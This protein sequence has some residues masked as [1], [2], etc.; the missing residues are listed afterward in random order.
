M[1]ATD[2][3]TTK[4]FTI[5]DLQQLVKSLKPKYKLYVVKENFMLN[6]NLYLL[7]NELILCTKECRDSII[8][9]N[10]FQVEELNDVQY[11]EYM[12]EKYNSEILKSMNKMPF[13]KE[14]NIAGNRE[15]FRM[16][17]E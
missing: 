9:S 8:D 4:E 5:G 2:N 16:K 12:N 13:I 11:H 14:E 10:E 3:T 7:Y 6:N 15:L 17:G 1:A